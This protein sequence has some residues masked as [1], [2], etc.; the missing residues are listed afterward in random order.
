M[1]K[2]S[3]QDLVRN[4]Q[5]SIRRIYDKYADSMLGYVYEV[6]KDR[7]LAEEY[8]VEIFCDISTHFDDNDLEENINWSK[9]QR[10]A[11]NKL[12]AFNDTIKLSDPG[13][14]AVTV[15]NSSN[16]YLDKLTDEQR[17][18]FCAAYYYGKSV[19]SISEELSIPKEQ[20][21]KTLKDAFSIIR[22]TSEN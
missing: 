11:K 6:V 1:P 14:V 9:L 10:F 3:I 21:Q 4:K 8:L 7:K 12:Q 13:T 15:H 2:L 16:M 17:L 20:V 19:I 18:V 22:K 5:I